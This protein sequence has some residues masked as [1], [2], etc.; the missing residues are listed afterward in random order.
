MYMVENFLSDMVNWP[1]GGEK[2]SKIM[3]FN[4]KNFFLRKSDFAAMMVFRA[5]QTKMSGRRRGTSSYPNILKFGLNILKGHKK[6][7]FSGFFLIV[8][9][10]L[11]SATQK[12]SFFASQFNTVLIYIL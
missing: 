12:L 6:F 8:I 7:N 3:K 10:A 1:S 11:S 5:D 2:A 4:K 9:V